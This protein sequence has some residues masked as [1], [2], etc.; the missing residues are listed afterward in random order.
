MQTSIINVIKVNEVKSGV[1]KS[2]PRQGAQWERHDCE[3]IIL[4]DDGSVDQVGV[5]VLNKDL[6]GKV[7]PGTYIGHYALRADMKTREI[8]PVLVSLVPYSA[9]TAA[10]KKAA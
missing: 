5:L 7:V 1:V 6:R 10:A 2:G 4:H 3:C 9:G 8:Q